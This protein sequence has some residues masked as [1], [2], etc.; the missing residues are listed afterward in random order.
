MSDEQHDHGGAVVVQAGVEAH[1]GSHVV[2]TAT[3]WDQR[4]VLP[5][6]GF[7]APD[8]QEL[9]QVPSVSLRHPARVEQG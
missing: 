3:V 5:E 9:H 4:H 1:E 7:E 8:G 6:Y 2:F